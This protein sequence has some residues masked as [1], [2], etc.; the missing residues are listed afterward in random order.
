MTEYAKPWL[1]VDAQ[2]AKLADRGVQI[3][4]PDACRKLLWAVGYYR[5]TGYLYPLRESELLADA[6]GETRLIIHSSYRPGTSIQIAEELISFD[7][8][9]RMLVL[10]GIERIEVSLRMQI[11]Y[12]LG[13][14][15]PFA[16]LDPENFVDSFTDE[17][18][19]RATGESAPSRHHQWIER[20]THRKAESKEAF[21]VHFRTKYD[22]KMPI[23]ALTE[24]LELGQLGVLYRGLNNSF[25]TTIAAHYGAPTKK[26]L[27]SWISSINYI[28]NVSAHHARLFNRKLV[29]APGRPKI[30]AVPVL[31][32][33]RNGSTTKEVFGL[34]NA[35]AVMAYLL[36]TTDPDS[37]WPTRLSQLISSFPASPLIDITSMGIP[38]GWSTLDLWKH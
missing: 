2:M 21:V 4:V 34:Y 7:R 37:G 28:R 20:V 29:A 8:S 9:L 17:Q 32:H 35:L 5:L 10:E 30:G 24:L 22:E 11:G 15:S 12:V 26:V 23:W 36:H 3:P 33:L 6:A 16:H 38:D 19:D 27:A 1:P 31:D 14:K 13:R 18:V 25:A